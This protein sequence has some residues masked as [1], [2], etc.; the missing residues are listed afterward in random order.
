VELKV[1]VSEQK[2]SKNMR[3]LSLSVVLVLAIALGAMRLAYTDWQVPGAN[4]LTWDAFG[5]Y[6]YLPGKFI[7]HDLG[8]LV[9]LP[10]ILEGYRPTGPLYQTIALPNGNFAMKYLMGLSILYA[11]FFFL[12]HWAAG[13]LGYPQD[14][15]SAP[16]PIAIC[17]GAWVYA[18]LGLLVLRRVL[19]RF[20]SEW[21]TALTLLLVGLATNYPQYVAVDSAMTHGF[22]F[23][24]YAVALLLIVRWHER[25]SVVGAFWVGLVIGLGSITR[26]TEGVMLFLAWLWSMKSGS[27]WAFFKQNPAQLGA[28]VLG[29]FLGI[30]PQ[31]IYWK[32]VTGGW[33]FD[34]GAKFLFFRPH[35]Q[36]LVGWEKGWLIYTPVAGLMLAGLF[37]LRSYPFRKAVLT[38]ALLNV[39]IVIA[40]ADWRY[41][42]SYSCRALVQSYPVMALPLAALL[43]NVEKNWLRWGVWL[44]AFFLVYLNLFQV[45]QYNRGIL[46]YNDMNRDYYR[47]IF[48][49]ARPSPL[50]MSLLDTKERPR[51]EGLLKSKG[52]LRLDSMYLI[53]KEKHAKAAL[54]EMPVRDLRGWEAGA[55]Q[56]L[57]VSVQVMSAWG[58]FDSWLVAELGAG[59]GQQKR[60]ACR[61]ENAICKKGAWN[62][63]E[64]YFC[65][66]PEWQGGKLRIGAETNTVQDIYIQGLTLTLLGR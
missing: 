52:V 18:L 64:F 60:T 29:G 26:P 8:K 27:K 15:F 63:I 47:A 65:L 33:I 36:V 66:P 56:W 32:A 39:W 6:L 17:F 55:E 30:L 4:V 24:V 31:L 2:R 51:D 25:P 35:W 11:P 49:S 7:Y 38:F 40:W 16:Y 19:R 43:Q 10:G 61:L 20:F 22:L 21:T 28:A 48:L 9:W 59:E 23:A 44:G 50:E 14:G 46:H 54:L 34:V 13:W 57:R 37:F 42:A 3:F 53:N 1:I 41:G 58:A 12:G 45:W 62:T 5:Y